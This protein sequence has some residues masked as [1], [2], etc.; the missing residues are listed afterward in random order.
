MFKEET[1]SLA[2]STFT[3][4]ACSSETYTASKYELLLSDIDLELLKKPPN[5]GN[6]PCQYSIGPLKYTFIDPLGISSDENGESL[7]LLCKSCHSALNR[8]KLPPLS[9]ANGTY[10]GPVPPELQ[11]LTP[12]KE[13][14]IARCCS[15][16]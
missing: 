12:I 16:C 8:D 9:L 7:L 5:S 3:C 4:T 15:K 10:L 1:S 13:A 14:M 11:D 2:L 6:L